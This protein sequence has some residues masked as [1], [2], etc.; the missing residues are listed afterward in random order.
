MSSSKVRYGW[1]QWM[2][3]AVLA[4]GVAGLV[5]I[6]MIA[7]ARL[8]PD[9]RPRLDVSEVQSQRQTESEGHHR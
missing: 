4:A 9:A 2:Y 3:L 5:A 7:N 6:T 1:F 8:G